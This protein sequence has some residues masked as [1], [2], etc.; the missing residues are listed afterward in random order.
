M[1]EDCS[2]LNGVNH[3]VP[4]WSSTQ[5][6]LWYEGIPG[7]GKYD[8][9]IVVPLTI[10]KDNTS[11]EKWVHTNNTKIH[12]KKGNNKSIQPNLFGSFTGMSF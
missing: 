7:E 2:I 10:A 6:P 12:S 9:P 11:I 4:I 3:Q 1:T 5:R 8:Y